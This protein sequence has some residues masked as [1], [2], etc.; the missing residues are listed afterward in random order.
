MS[1]SANA[2]VPK[3]K[4][5][6]NGKRRAGGKK[7]AYKKKGSAKTGKAIEDTGAV[8][9]AEMDSNAAVRVEIVDGT[10]EADGRELSIDSGIS[11]EIKNA[12]RGRVRIS[13]RQ[14]LRKRDLL[15]KLRSYLLTREGVKKV[16]TNHRC[17]SVTIQYD[18]AVLN[19][20]QLLSRVRRVSVTQLT[21]WEPPPQEQEAPGLAGAGGAVEL[22]VL[23][24]RPRYLEKNTDLHGAKLGYK[25][26]HMTDGRLRVS[27][28]LLA[29][30][31]HLARCLEMRLSSEQGVTE[32]EVNARCGSFRIK[33]DMEMVRAD[34]LLGKLD[35][36]TLRELFEIQ[37]E[38]PVRV[39]EDFEVS[40]RYLK[41]ATAGVGLSVAFGAVPVLALPLVYPLLIYICWP[42]YKRAARCA[43]K[44]RRLNV[45]F[46]DS[47][48][49]TVG[50][51][52][53]DVMNAAL[54]TWLI[55]LG[56]YI[57]DLTAASSNKTIRKLLDFQENY[58]WIVRDGV[59]VKVKVK[60][61]QEDDVVSLNV[62]DLIPVDGE[63]V[64]GELIVDQQVLTGESMPIH[65]EAG[66]TVLAATVIKDGKAYVKVSRTG[67]RTKVAQVVK[68]VE[69]APMYETKIQNH[70]EK[71]ADRLVA[72]SLLTTGAIFATTLS[73]PQLAALATVDFGT[74]VRVSAPTAVLSS[75]IAS[76]S[77]GILIKGGSYL[78]KLCSVDTIVFD[79]TGTLTTGV[80]RVEDIFTFNGYSSEELLSFAAT[81][82]L[83]MTHP[84]AEA[85]VNEAEEQ[86]LPLRKRDEVKYVVGRGVEARI[87]GKAVLVGSMRL[88]K[89]NEIP[90]ASSV[91]EQT[92]QCVA[93]GKA[94]LYVSIDGKLCGIIAFRDQIRE[95]A[96]EMIDALHKVGVKQVIML[97]GDVKKVAIPVANSLGID[98]CIAEVLP[99]Q[100][101]EVIIQL[102]KEGHLVAFVGDGINDSVALTYADIGISVKGGSDIT[103]ESAGVILLD[104]NLLKIPKAFE[105][106]K[107]TIRLI[108]EN[109][110]IV[111][112]FNVIAYGLA[113]VGLLSPVLTTLI[114]NGSAVVACINGMKPTI[115]IKLGEAGKKKVAAPSLKELRAA[116]DAASSEAF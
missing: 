103:K 115:R 76:A 101:A 92:D 68:M 70:A 51:M 81:A 109:Y 25:V 78:E 12:F 54:M 72:P 113:A 9:A 111:G 110:Q 15:A 108:K 26:Q 1:A 69:E 4:E 3:D 8:P 27:V 64:E 82:E 36:I 93:D 87:E 32:V 67:D 38:L 79:K 100:K 91:E 85:V 18:C 47:L 7:A 45:D 58:A 63:V 52:T 57:R 49:L 48:A 17:G 16:E 56:D 11:Y 94:C 34:D 5:K 31:D 40:V 39:E 41:L 74:G 97:T 80:I 106:S 60:D 75:M 98:R 46:L 95:E 43:V 65:K 114:S 6:S 84:I 104:D 2:P 44:E 71:F 50:M 62:G 112:G 88:Q 23:N 28:P 35:T 116:A 22:E 10:I 30:Y 77:Q 29:S 102:K 53:G 107:Q 96:R 19:Q 73:L 89:E 20:G 37:S 105:I 59:E 66:D 21:E 90:I 61:L 24:R 14:F 13:S 55:H 33:H 86:G 99:E 42:V 83:Q